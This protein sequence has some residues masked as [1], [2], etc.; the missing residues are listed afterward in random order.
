M[1]NTAGN[2]FKLKIKLK[3]KYGGLIDEIKDS[4]KEKFEVKIMLPDKSIINCNKNLFNNNE[5]ILVFENIITLAGESTFEVKYNNKNVK[6]NNCKVKVNPNKMN[7]DNIIINYINNESII[8]LNKNNSTNINKDNNLMFEALCYDEYY[9]KINNKIDFETKF[10]GFEREIALCQ[11]KKESSI[12]ISLCDNKSTKK[13]WSYLGNGEYFLEV[14]YE[15]KSINYPLKI[16]IDETNV[17]NTYI[18]TNEIEIIV[19]DY[20]NFSVELRTNDGKRQNYWYE[21]PYS[22][23]EVSFTNNEIC[24]SNITIGD[25]PGQYY[26]KI[27]STNKIGESQIILNIEGKEI[28]KK[29]N[30]KVIPYDVNVFS[31]NDTLIENNILPSGNT[32]NPYI[33]KLELLDI[34]NKAIDCPDKFSYQ[35]SNSNT[36]FT[37][38]DCN[39][40]KTLYIN[41]SFSKMGEYSFIIPIINKTYSFNI[42]HGEPINFI[43]NF[44]EKIATGQNASIT[45]TLDAKDKYNNSIPK[46]EFMRG[47]E[48][49]FENE[50]SNYSNFIIEI[51]E[52]ELIKYTTNNIFTKQSSYHWKISY[53]GKNIDTSQDYITS[54]IAFLDPTNIN[55]MLEY[56]KG[57]TRNGTNYEYEYGNNNVEIYGYDKYSNKVKTSEFKLEEAYINNNENNKINVSCSVK[58]EYAY[59]CNF[60]G[61]GLGSSPY[62]LYNYT[63][64]N[65]TFSNYSVIL[66]NPLK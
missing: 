51:I 6:C 50:E 31:S 42:N 15:N 36:T 38:Y 11:V 23:I 55:I 47:L 29:I 19:G 22:E 65:Y 62:I 53:N 8:K 32:D 18:S 10:K 1:I 44:T 39:S 43:K 45:L 46:D 9:N 4:D 41:N 57:A 59:L 16:E 2:I 14:E 52:N 5:N 26:I 64:S 58:N 7:L 66:I 35:F 63:A 34:N 17:N 25:E 24:S 30:L 61:N 21:E 28:Q 54:V 12:V 60:N 13:N 3:D 27:M 37:D 40:N 20:K 33:I 49:I 56:D 48:I